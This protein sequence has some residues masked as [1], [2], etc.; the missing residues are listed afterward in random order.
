M[1]KIIGVLKYTWS[2]MVAYYQ[3]ARYSCSN[4]DVSWNINTTFVTGDDSV[5]TLK[6]I[7]EGYTDVVDKISAENK[8]ITAEQINEKLK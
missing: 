3:T 8:I 5:E 7:R 1:K 4:E 6:K 2:M